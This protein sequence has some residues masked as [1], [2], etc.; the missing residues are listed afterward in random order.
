M[1]A[2]YD[3]L[4]MYVVPALGTLP[5]AFG[6]AEGDGD[7]D[8]DE[9]PDL[10]SKIED[11][12]EDV[13]PEEALEAFKDQASETGSMEAFAKMLYNENQSLREKRR[14]LQQRINRLE[15][16]GPEDAV[17]LDSDVA[18][19]LSERLPEGKG[20]E[21]LPEFLDEAYKAI[22]QLHETKKK[23]RR[24]K[25]ADV[26]DVDEEALGDL[27]PEADFEIRTVEDEDS[28]EEVQQALIDTGDDKKPLSDY[29]EETYPSFETVLFD[30]SGSEDES[31]DES[32]PSVPGPSGDE[33]ED[34]D[35][36]EEGGD[37]VVQSW[38]ESQNFAVPEVEGEE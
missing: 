14:K 15:E 7:E 33:D 30:S 4:F 11:K 10:E 13:M 2:L 26:A 32:G 18:E 28:G 23:E 5:F 17:V 8:R 29:L 34:V 20:I 16:N 21:D 35:A 19:K 38:R 27:E 12:L 1:S 25:A 31:E 37:D 9:D 22:D 24:Q 6:M 36:T 3:F